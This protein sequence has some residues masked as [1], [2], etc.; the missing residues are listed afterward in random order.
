MTNYTIETKQLTKIYKDQKAVNNVNIHVKK[1]R[2]YGLLGR[3]GAGK[4]TIMKMILGL[5]STSSGEVDVF[6]KNIKG[7]EKQV[8]PRIGAII[9]T[10]GFYPNL[11]GTENLNIFAKLR[12][13]SAPNAVKNALEIVGLPYK[14]KKLFGEYSLGMKQRLGIANAILHDPELL[15]LDEPTNGLDPIGI[16]EVRDFI[17]NLSVERGKTILISSHI[18]SEISLL[19]DDIGIIDNG[20]LLEENS[21]EE[22]KRKNGKYILLEVSDAAKASLILERQFD[23]KSYSVKDDH[24]LQIYDNSLDMA[25]VNKALILGDVSVISSQLCNDTLEDYFRKITGGDGIA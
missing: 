6:G 10:P 5:T 2:I 7:R 24:T 23:L 3:N 21:M 17:K 4:T 19:A 25:S 1:G 11:T 22:L 15:I 16:A 13:T 18:L 20:V 14:D 9:E 12:G 8:Y